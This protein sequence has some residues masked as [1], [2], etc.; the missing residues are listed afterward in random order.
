MGVL[1][2]GALCMGVFAW[3]L[4]A[5][6]DPKG[7]IILNHITWPD[8]F[9]MILLAAG[10]GFVSYFL[11]WPYG[12]Q[13]G[14]FAAPAGLAVWAIRSDYLTSLIQLHPL[15]SDRQAVIHS[16]R[17]SPFFWLLVVFSCMAG[18]HVASR[19]LKSPAPPLPDSDPLEGNKRYVYSVCG[20]AC[21]L[22]LAHIFIGAF[23]QGTALPQG[24]AS[25]QPLI[26]Q[27]AFGVFLAFG[28]TSFIVKHFFNL[29][30]EWTMI[31]IAFVFLF[32]AV[33]VGRTDTM[34]AAAQ[35]YPASVITHQILSILPVQLVAF[36]SMGTIAGYWAALAYLY[37]RK[38][39]SR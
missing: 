1:T 36:G 39:E 4:V 30:Y 3:P 15:V 27:I 9:T 14:I 38:H 23:V 34:T 8:R 5:P 33:W 18:V 21:A 22:I 10:L 13:I 17:W 26:G 24:R 29:R 2:L 32:N 11:A 37:W 25:A 35:A 12:R 6:P 31:T 28:V 19:L 7:V 16:L 20:F